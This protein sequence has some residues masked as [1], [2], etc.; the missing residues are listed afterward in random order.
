MS[1]SRRKSRKNSV[2]HQNKKSSDTNIIEKISVASSLEED[3]SDNKD[4]TEFFSDQSKGQ[5]ILDSLKKLEASGRSYSIE[6]ARRL[7]CA[8]GFAK[9][10]FIAQYSQFDRSP[11]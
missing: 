10:R 5:L 1:S 7:N 3:S 6:E 4:L 9:A 2:K 11:A 8:D